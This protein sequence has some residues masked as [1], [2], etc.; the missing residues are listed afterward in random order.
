V[1]K[2]PALAPYELLVIRT[3]RVFKWRVLLIRGGASLPSSDD[4]AQGHNIVD[5]RPYPAV[6][7]YLVRPSVSG[8]GRCQRRFDPG[9]A[10]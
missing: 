6:D 5:A 4:L 8:R 3:A 2:R 7:E 9:R 1:A 10:R